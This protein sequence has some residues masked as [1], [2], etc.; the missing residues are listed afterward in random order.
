MS[1]LYLQYSQVFII[2]VCDLICPAKLFLFVVVKSH[3]EHLQID[4][5]ED[6]EVEDEDVVEDEDDVFFCAARKRAAFPSSQKQSVG[7][8]PRK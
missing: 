4:E 6:D 5:V 3:F 8:P 2:P 1:L 7:L